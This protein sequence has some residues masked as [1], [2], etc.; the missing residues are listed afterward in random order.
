MYAR[1]FRLVSF[2]SFGT[3]LLAA[4]GT[5]NPTPTAAL[6]TSAPLP[7]STL[8]ASSTPTASSTPAS[9]ETPAASATPASTSTSSPTETP[10][11][12]ETPSI[13]VTAP[14]TSAPAATPAIATVAPT[15]ISLVVQAT[16]PPMDYV[17][18]YYRIEVCSQWAPAF[19]IV[20]TGDA[21]LSSYTITVK[22]NNTK[23]S[24]SRQSNN[25]DQRQGCSMVSDTPSLNY[26]QVGYIYPKNFSYDPT[27]DS[28]TADVT[29]CTRDNLAGKCLE[30]SIAFTP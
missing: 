23:V 11:A 28:L 20:N 1:L 25:F 6:A 16:N 9:T 15:A 22:D 14:A 18:V 12:T 30:M 2:I 4:C 27:G 21:T 29:V 17:F 19:K 3:L 26:G 13:T 7:T 5:G 24:L 8:A 10:A